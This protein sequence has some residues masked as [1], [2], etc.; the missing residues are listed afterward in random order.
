M[1]IGIFI[2]SYC[3]SLKYLFYKTTNR[4]LEAVRCDPNEQSRDHIPYCLSMLANDG[5]TYGN[6]CRTFET[7]SAVLPSW[8]WLPWLP[9]LLSSLCRVE[10]RAMKAILV[11]ILKDH[12][13]ALYYSLRSFYLER[14]DIERPKGQKVDDD[15]PSSSR[16]AEEFMSN[17]RKVHPVLWSKLES[18]LE[19]LI[20]RFR[21]SYE[22][23]LLHS[24][25]ASLQKVS[26]SDYKTDPSGQLDAC[27]KMLGAKFFNFNK[28]DGS[29]TRKAALFRAKYASLF[30]SDFLGEKEGPSDL[31]VKLQKWKKLLEL[32]ISRVPKKSNLQEVS[33]SLSWFSSQ[34]PDLWAGAC[35][36]KSLT[37][38]NSQHEAHASLDNAFYRAKKSS[39]LAA[40]KASSQAVLVAANSEG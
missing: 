3:F 15:T 38:S 16:L 18:I 26:K 36:S 29:I 7:R 13:Q 27:T 12:P 23:E 2:T 11:G 37:I 14:R 30:K 35:E 1:Y 40:A 4:S 10:A 9:Q 8:V 19:D 17:L 33:P 5:P 20:V 25:V 24:I 31:V 39:A 32:G 28:P 21:P 34:A 22:A 6:L